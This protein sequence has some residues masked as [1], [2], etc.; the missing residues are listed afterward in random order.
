LRKVNQRGF[1]AFRATWVTLALSA[2]VPIDLVRKVTGHTTVETVLT[3]YIHPDRED[4]RKAIEN[5][6]P[7]LFLE[8]STPGA[9]L[10]ATE[11]PK[12]ALQEALKALEAMTA[13]NW[14]QQRDVV[15][16]FVLQAGGG[17]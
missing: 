17:N 8:T 14:R 1:H 7:R 12:A 13:K 5:A 3:H 9:M 11:P 6:M 2:G 16:G 10:P 4:F 15:A